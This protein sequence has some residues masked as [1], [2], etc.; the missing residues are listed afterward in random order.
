MGRMAD[1]NNLI[2]REPFFDRS[3]CDLICR[4]PQKQKVSGNPLQL[5]RTRGH[6]KKALFDTISTSVLPK[7]ILNKP[8]GG[9]VPPTG[10]WLH[11]IIGDR[12]LNQILS[13]DLCNAGYFDLDFVQRI[14]NEHR[15][16][17]R[18]WGRLIYMLLVVDIW[19]RTF[20]AKPKVESLKVSLSGL[21]NG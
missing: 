16:G 2:V 12:P 15:T 7:D 17:H 11:Q 8:K 5:M 3:V 10:M 9:F 4:L 13:Q 20:I 19:H 14:F 18:N 6:I 1:A 21:W